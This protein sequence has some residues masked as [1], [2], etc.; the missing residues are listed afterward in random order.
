MRICRDQ[1][2]ACWR[3][4]H[5]L[6]IIRIKEL[7]FLLTLNNSKQVQLIKHL[8]ILS[9]VTFWKSDQFILIQH[10]QKIRMILLE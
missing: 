1:E 7:R 6:Q 9:N 2:R 10:F 3:G 8:T 4:A 5:L